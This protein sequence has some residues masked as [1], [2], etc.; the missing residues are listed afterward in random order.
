MVEVG[1]Y[2]LIT[3]ESEVVWIIYKVHL[4]R[5][6]EFQRSIWELWTNTWEKL[7]EPLTEKEINN[8]VPSAYLQVMF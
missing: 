2:S 7:V 5:T 3:I 8:R 6:T 1:L 4:R